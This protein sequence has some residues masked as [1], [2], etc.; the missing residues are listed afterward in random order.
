M[1]FLVPLY[2]QRYWALCP[3]MHGLDPNYIHGQGYDGAGNMAGKCRCAAA[4]IQRVYPKAMYL[5]TLNLC[6]VADCEA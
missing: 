1:M 5:H 4:C 6:L 2:Q 3:N